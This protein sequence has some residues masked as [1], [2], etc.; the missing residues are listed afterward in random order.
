MPLRLAALAVLA[1]VLLGG[2]TAASAQSAAAGRSPLAVGGARA[3]RRGARCGRGG[4]CAG[5]GRRWSARTVA[6][7]CI[8]APPG[9][10]R[11]VPAV[12]PMTLDT[13]FDVAS[14][15]KVVATMPAV[16]ALWEEGRI[17]LDA[18]LGRYLKEFAAPRF[19]R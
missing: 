19:A 11:S 15:T 7:R 1:F 16:L 8:A 14:L 17:D 12:E 9:R 4:R 2:A 3:R 13:V 10:A 6:S 5:S 18:P